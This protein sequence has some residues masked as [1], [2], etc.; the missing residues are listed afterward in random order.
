MIS[1]NNSWGTFNHFANV[2]IVHNFFFFK[3]PKISTISL[4]QKVW[5]PCINHDQNILILQ[6]CKNCFG[7]HTLSGFL[8]IKLPQQFNVL[9]NFHILCDVISKNRIQ[10]WGHYVLFIVSDY[11]NKELIELHIYWESQ[12]CRAVNPGID[13][14]PLLQNQ[15]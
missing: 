13:P 2:R 8:V 6:T 12:N 15:A 10:Y 7:S 3:R 14:T 9:D 1:A 5:G 4:L 11:L